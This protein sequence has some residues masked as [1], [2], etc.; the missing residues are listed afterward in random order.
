M[1]PM[2]VLMPARGRRAA[3]L[4]WF[5]STVAATGKE[6]ESFT[7]EL[8][9][10]QVTLL[11]QRI[12]DVYGTSHTHRF[13]GGLHDTNPKRRTWKALRCET[14]PARDKVCN[15]WHCNCQG[16]SN[17]FDT[18]PG[19]WGE[20]RAMFGEQ[21]W[22][23]KMRCATQPEPGRYKPLGLPDGI[24]K[25]ALMPESLERWLPTESNPVER[26]V[27]IIDSA[28]GVASYE[29]SSM[30]MKWLDGER[31]GRICATAQEP[32]VVTAAHEWL[33]FSND[34]FRSPRVKPLAPTAAQAAVLSY[35]HTAGQKEPIEPLH[36]VAR[37]PFAKVGCG[38]DAD[39]FNLTYLVLRNAC[40]AAE[41]PRVLL[42][43][44]GASRG[45]M[46]VPGGVFDTLPNG[47]AKGGGRAPSVPFLYTM[48]KD[49]CLEPDAIF[50]WEM[51]KG[52]T[53]REFWGELPPDIRH[54]VRFYELPV[55]E[56][57]LHDSIAGTLEPASFLQMLKAVARHE[58]YVVVKLDVDTPFVE[59]T[60]I[61][62]LTARLDLAGLIDE[63]FFEYHFNTREFDLW[64]FGQAGTVDTALATM[65]KLRTLG[66][67]A[68]F[69]I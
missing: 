39:I 36:G 17:R 43:D 64:H 21:E 65:H 26:M 56:G 50:A 34:G 41:K 5:A 29:S 10:E 7:V 61:T 32:D 14:T 68:H 27:N 18:K 3:S 52:C 37:H 53:E 51:N 15:A 60:I 63:L 11:C 49:R 44:M 8:D 22:W 62:T 38:G 25:E 20:A 45:F 67:R 19:H 13:W 23:L 58:D 2:P 28:S 30:E 31:S 55:T 42:F 16:F 46:G 66:I 6:L 59:Q 35:F 9:P 40:G 24:P 57:E 48:F 47:G 12:S 33:K 54:K 4:A 69:W 1:S